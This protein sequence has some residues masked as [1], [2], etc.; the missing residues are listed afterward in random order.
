MSKITREE[1]VMAEMLLGLMDRVE[2]PY[3]MYQIEKDVI[4]KALRLFLADT[5][6]NDERV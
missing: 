2:H 3:I 5:E 1:Q 6:V 4:K